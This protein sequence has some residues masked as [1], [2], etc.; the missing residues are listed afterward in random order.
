[1]TFRGFD[2]LLQQGKNFGSAIMC[3]YI[4]LTD[5]TICSYTEYTL[6]YSSVTWTLQNIKFFFIQKDFE[7]NKIQIVLRTAE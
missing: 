4:F 5:N 7:I 2:S 6:L 1:M 3:R